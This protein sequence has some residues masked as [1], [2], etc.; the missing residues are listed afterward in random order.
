MSKFK[1]EIDAKFVE[2][3][4]SII[5]H[6]TQIPYYIYLVILVLGW[7]EFMAV[8]R[9]PFFFTLLLVLG[10]ALYVMYQTNLL[11]PALL[12][13]QRMLDEAVLVGKQKLRE[14]VVDDHGAH[15]NNLKKMGEGEGSIELDDL[16]PQSEADE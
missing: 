7:N 11:G 3:K 2:T 9:N 6:V 10:A 14:F 8:L 16:E 1:R 4:R 5:Q 12:V 15:S 13:T